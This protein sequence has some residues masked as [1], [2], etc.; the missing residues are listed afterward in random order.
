[1]AYDVAWGDVPTWVTA[2]ATIGAFT[3]AGFAAWS[4]WRVLA[5]ENVREA[6][7]RDARLRRQ[8]DGVAAWP[9]IERRERIQF[10]SFR[11]IRQADMYD[12][13][14]AGI[15]NSS[16]LPVYNV[17][18]RWFYPGADGELE[19]RATMAMVA[20]VPPGGDFLAMTDHSHR[21]AVE[22]GRDEFGNPFPG[23]VDRFELFRLEIDFTDTAGNRWRRSA[24]GALAPL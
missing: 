1:M 17:V 23:N 7:E 19:L 10:Q 15:G 11:G 2:I 8:A 3:A 18:V 13:E 9:D 21:R 24:D 20:V 16:P 14:G 5:K 6:Q 22:E 4:A 12:Q